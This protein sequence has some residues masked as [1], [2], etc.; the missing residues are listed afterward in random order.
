M[1]TSRYKWE[2]YFVWYFGVGFAG[3]PLVLAIE[4]ASDLVDW[5]HPSASRP[6]EIVSHGAEFWVSPPIWWAH[7]IGL[8]LFIS[9]LPALAIYLVVRS[10]LNGWNS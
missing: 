1:T 10:F 5:S 6:A 3:I 8:Y 4:F 2:R 7:Q 9:L